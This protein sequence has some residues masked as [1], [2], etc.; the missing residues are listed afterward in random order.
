MTDEEVVMNLIVPA[1]TAKS[2]AIESI[3]AARKHDF[4]RAEQLLAKAD[5]AIVD[6]HEHQSESIRAVLNGE[7]DSGVSLI[8]V[9]G[10]DHL[11]NAITTI[12]LA[13]QIVGL[14]HELSE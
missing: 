12:D 14:L 6:A 3:A 10:Q 13:R 1:G 7:E 4:E 2:A 9:H 11:M 5:A 8:M